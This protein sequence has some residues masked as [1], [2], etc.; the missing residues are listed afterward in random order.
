MAPPTGLWGYELYVEL[1][2]LLTFIYDSGYREIDGR[3]IEYQALV[4]SNYGVTME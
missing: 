3:T 4:W 1:T 2:G